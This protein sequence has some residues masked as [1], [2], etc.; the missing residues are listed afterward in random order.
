[1]NPSQVI[2]P[3][4]KY[5]GKSIEQVYNIDT[6]YLEMYLEMHSDWYLILIGNQTASDMV[7]QI[8]SA[9]NKCKQRDKDCKTIP[10]IFGKEDKVLSNYGSFAPIHS[11]S[12][13]WMQQSCNQSRFFESS[14][15]R[16][17]L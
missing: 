13:Y 8:V 3:F 5:K 10:D 6:S 16:G 12:Y 1:M 2:I 9:I 7:D 15:H 17:Y 14:I 4:G 11:G